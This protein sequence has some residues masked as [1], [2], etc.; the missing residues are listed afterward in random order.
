MS[1]YVNNLFSF[2]R[3]LPPPFDTLKSKKVKVSSKYGSGT[4]STL[5]SS[6]IKAIHAYITPNSGAVG[7]IDNQYTVT[8]YQSSMGPGIYHLVIY[9]KSNGNFLASVY[10][11]NS[12]TME[13]Y[14][15][16]KNNR[17]GAA[18]LMAM[19]PVFLEDSEF[20][21]HFSSYKEQFKNGYPDMKEAINDMAILCDN[22][23]RRI[24]DDSC[25]MYVKVNLDRSGNLMRISQAQLD[26]GVYTPDTVLTGEFTVFSQNNLGS[27]Q[28]TQPYIDHND[29]I[30]KYK[31][32]KRK[33]SDIEET[34][35]PKL[36]EWYV[37]PSEAVNICKHINITTDTSVPMRNFLLRGPAGTG[38]TMTAKA[39]ASGLHLPYVKY[40]CSSNTEI[41]DLVGM[42]LPNLESTD[43]SQVIQKLET[44]QGEYNYENISA[45]LQLP[46]TDD[47]YYDPKGTYKILTGIDH[48]DATIKDCI[49]IVLQKVVQK[50]QQLCESIEKPN[51]T[52]QKYT[53]M[54][55]ELI[56]ALKYG[57][58]VEI[59]EPTTITQ[60]GVLVGLNSLLEQN[61]TITLPTGEVITRHPDAVV[62]VTTNMDYEGCRNLNQSVVDRMSMV[63]TVELPST[64]T[65][66][67]RVMSITGCTD[68]LMIWNMVQVVKDI[69]EYMR[70]Y[71][72]VDGVCGMR[73]LIDW[74]ISTEI[75]G[76]VHDA[77]LYTVINKSTSNVEDQEALITSALEPIFPPKRLRMRA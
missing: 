43:D 60:S 47:I 25:P 19:M 70:K 57:Y 13:I 49:E 14:T 34:L 67:Q 50:I 68:E 24:K 26:S 35:V 15:V 37:I 73:S 54:E 6:V 77:A 75:I 61:G 8:E 38:K 59:Q 71:S 64:E 74:V 52:E 5:C 4:E 27:I 10:N 63:V 45:L 65:M 55:T 28:T 1:A 32:S 69:N 7:I 2:S 48:T 58:V 9:D 17:D 56:R 41:F 51:S 62:I 53:Y 23:Y 42:V 11:I 66:V 40:T 30:G 20:D 3:P 46:D 31:N 44:K 12:E 72:I 29:F 76:D 21:T 33:L 39:I 36:P 18:L 22:V 16:N